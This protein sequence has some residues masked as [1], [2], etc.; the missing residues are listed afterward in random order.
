MT[1]RINSTGEIEN[2][3]TSERQF[4]ATKINIQCV[5][6]L[7]LREIVDACADDDLQAYCVTIYPHPGAQPFSQA[8]EALWLVK[9]GRLGIAWGADADWADADSVEAGIEMWLNDPEEWIARN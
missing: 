2:I 1:H 5:T 7:D 8:A 4:T 9:E 3:E 6:S